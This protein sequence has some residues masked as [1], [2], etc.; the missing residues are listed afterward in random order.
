MAEPPVNFPRD[1]LAWLAWSDECLDAGDEAGARFAR[2]VASAIRAGETTQWLSEVLLLTDYL[3]LVVGRN[4]VLL[5]TDCA[6]QDCRLAQA[7][8]FEMVGGSSA[9]QALRWCAA[10]NVYPLLVAFTHDIFPAATAHWRWSSQSEV[11]PR[12][13]HA[14]PPDLF[15][16]LPR[17]PQNRKQRYLNRRLAEEALWRAWEMTRRENGR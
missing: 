8:A 10:Q 1:G 16:A 4:H 12:L 17:G 3:N 6:L 9:A 14:L 5:D 2:E 7:D 15:E 13:P 11:S